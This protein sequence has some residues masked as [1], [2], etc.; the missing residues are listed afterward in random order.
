MERNFKICSHSKVEFSPNMDKVVLHFDMDCFYCQVEAKRLNVPMSTPLVVDQWGML[1]SVNYPAKA[2][3]ISR[4]TPAKDAACMGAIVAHV[5]VVDIETGEKFDDINSAY[6]DRVLYKASLDRYRDASEEVMIVMKQALPVGAAF[7][8]ASIDEC[9]IDISSEDLLDLFPDVADVSRLCWEGGCAYDSN[10]HQ[11]LILARGALLGERIRSEVFSVTGYTASCGVALTRQVAKLCCALNKPNKLTVVPAARLTEFMRTIPLK[12][13]RGLGPKAMETLQER[14]PWVQGSTLC[15]DLWQVDIGKDDFGKWMYDALRGLND[16]QVKDTSLTPGSVQSSKQ[17]RPSLPLS[18]VEGMLHSLTA[19]M[20]SRL[21]GRKAKTLV[22]ILQVGETVRSRQEKFPC[23][24]SIEQVGSLVK[25]LAQKTGLMQPPESTRGFDRLAVTAKDVDASNQ[26]QEEKGARKEVAEYLASS[27][28]HFMGTWKTRYIQFISEVEDTGI[29]ATGELST[30]AQDSLGRLCERVFDGTET[31]AI[32]SPRYLLVDMDCFFCSVA[33][34]VRHI[35]ESKPCAVA[36]GLGL[37]SEICSAN[38]EA[39]K[40]GV[41]ASSF[42]SSAKDKCPQIE[43]IAIDSATLSRCETIWKQVIH[44]L[45][46]LAGRSFQRIQGKSCDEA[47]VDLSSGRLNVDLIEI[48]K[49][50]QDIITRECGVPC[51][52]GIAPT[53]V[54]AK[55]ATSKAKPKGV[56]VIGSVQEGVNLISGDPVKSL[57]GIGYSTHAKLN[58]IGVETV[59]DLFRV[60]SKLPGLL[61]A[62]NAKKIL[63]VAQGQDLDDDGPSGTHPTTVSAEKNFGLRNLSLQQSIDLLGALCDAAKQ[64]CTP[65]SAV[66]KAVLKLKLASDDWVEPAKK[67]GIG[68]AYDWSKTVDITSLDGLISILSPLLKDIDTTRIRGIGVALRIKPLASTA[69]KATLENFFVGNV[70]DR[71]RPR[72]VIEPLPKKFIENGVTDQCVVCG[73]EVLVGHLTSHFVSHLN[74]DDGEQV[75]P[76]PICFEPIEL[77]D[78][79]HV[80]NHFSILNS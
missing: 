67:G 11:D 41:T 61:G 30:G 49:E 23:P 79:T 2:L 52:V 7:E 29:W 65:R 24:G 44:S 3:G 12:E 43:I 71:K 8:R 20:I 35:H 50:L 38:Y 76:C 68:D 6:R 46:L 32:T 25:E 37:T 51:S 69:G 17:F 48:G 13:I 54:L 63:A 62:G 57:P 33:M 70:P 22:V 73:A 19:D 58:A 53:R 77:T 45:F 36:S 72:E 66:E 4:K 64:R 80:S 26:E 78:A 47:L 55:L 27:R 59:G 31:N 56:R 75:C 40:F 9:Y 28:L 39:R 5:R 15:G 34:S 42:V 14:V 10:N 74:G 18:Q 16:D 60:Q 1:L 21:E